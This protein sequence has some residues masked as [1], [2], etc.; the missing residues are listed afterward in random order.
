VRPGQDEGGGHAP[1][2]Q[3]G[4]EAD[5]DVQTHLITADGAAGPSAYRDHGGP[6]AMRAPAWQRLGAC[7]VRGA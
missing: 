7:R 6:R 2:D 4:A 1:Q 5:L 3:R